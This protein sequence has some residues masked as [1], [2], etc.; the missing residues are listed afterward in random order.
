MKHKFFKFFF[1]G[2]SLL[3]TKNLNQLIEIEKD[4]KDLLLFSRKHKNL[5]YKNIKKPIISRFICF[6]HFK[7]EERKGF[8]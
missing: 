3:K 8:L 1:L 6:I 5:N 4:V 2:L 7:L